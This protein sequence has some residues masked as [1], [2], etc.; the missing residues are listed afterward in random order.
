MHLN[1]SHPRIGERLRERLALKR[2]NPIFSK[3]CG[4]DGVLLSG[5]Q[6]ALEKPI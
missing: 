3:A 2:K 5:L 6:Q 1:P 4:G